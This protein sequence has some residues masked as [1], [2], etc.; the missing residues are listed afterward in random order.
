MNLDEI[1]NAVNHHSYISVTD[2]RG[3]IIYVNDKFSAVSGYSR[4][5]L[6]GSKHNILKSGVHSTSFYEEMWACIVNG[7]IWQGD[8]CNKNKKG[9]LFWSKSTIIPIFNSKGELY[10][11]ISIKTDIS[12]KISDQEKLR[13]MSY[14]DTLTGAPNRKAI[15]ESINCTIDSLSIVRNYHLL[16][17]VD[18][19]SFKR[20]NDS[21]GHVYGDKILCIVTRRLRS[22]CLTNASFGRYGGDEFLVLINSES[23]DLLQSMVFFQDEI[24]RLRGYLDFKVNMEELSINITS[25]IGGYVYSDREQ[26]VNEIIRKTDIALY[27]AKE[28]GKNTYSLYEKSFENDVKSKILR[29][30]IM[31]S[32]FFNQQFTI[33]FQPI[34]DINGSGSY[35]E[36]QLHWYHP[37]KGVLPPSEFMP[38]LESSGLIIEVGD[39]V[40]DFICKKIASMIHE[41]NYIKVSTDISGAQIKREDF[42]EKVISNL[43]RYK[44]PGRC[45]QFEI[46]EHTLIENAQSAIKVMQ[47]LAKKG[48][49][50]ALADFGTGYSS[51]ASLHQLPIHSVK[52]DTS[53]VKRVLDKKSS[54]PIIQF[55]IK[56]SKEYNILVVAEGVDN[57]NQLDAIMPLGCDF[58]QGD[59]FCNVSTL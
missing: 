52:I 54:L 44:I 27:V 30:S 34:I 41:N 3:Y 29:T 36:A 19:D 6:I 7:D 26:S 21:F 9:N 57:K 14:V 1:L 37:D 13:K 45:L 43:D 4:E 59:Y 24:E 2:K 38:D 17:L 53:F 49:T 46:T 8:I 33:H 39:Y 5:E 15:L 51:L 10:K 22:F 31:K 16:L 42:F 47:L 35:F 40:L 48:I 18:L 50:F 28:S 58:Y 32:A 55:M 20:I 56:M 23:D 12:D 25:S 11:I